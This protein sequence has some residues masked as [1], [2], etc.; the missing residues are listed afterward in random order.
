MDPVQSI[1][2][3]INYTFYKNTQKLDQ[4]VSI[5]LEKKDKVKILPQKAYKNKA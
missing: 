2:P 1:S 4:D 5:N 3:G